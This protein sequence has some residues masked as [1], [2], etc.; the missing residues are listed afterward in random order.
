MHAVCLSTHDDLVLSQELIA[1]VRILSPKSSWTTSDAADNDLRCVR[2]S[3]AELEN[4]YIESL[5]YTSD[6]FKALNPSAAIGYRQSEPV[7][8]YS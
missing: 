6:G 1:I 2:G 5:H 8:S 3:K 4:A 7:T